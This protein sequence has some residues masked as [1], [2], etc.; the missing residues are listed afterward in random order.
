MT[1]VGMDDA[2]V[3]EGTWIDIVGGNAID[4]ISDPSKIVTPA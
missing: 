1:R 4:S 3:E 2:P